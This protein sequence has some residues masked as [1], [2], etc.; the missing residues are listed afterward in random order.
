MEYTFRAVTHSPGIIIWRIEVICFTAVAPVSFFFFF[1]KSVVLYQNEKAN[2]NVRHILDV[3]RSLVDFSLCARENGAGTNPGEVL[4]KLLRGWLLHTPVCK[5]EKTTRASLW[6]GLLSLFVCFKR[7]IWMK[8]RRVC[9]PRQTV[10]PILESFF[11]PPDSEGEQLSVLWHPLL[12]RLSV[13]SGRTGRSCCLHHPV[14]WVSGILSSPAPGGSEPWM[15]H[16]Q[17]LL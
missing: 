7:P 12:D 3:H 6:F 16:L 11:F 15:W 14:G 4:R 1:S 13:H 10:S 8:H 9:L 2:K 17:G 5:S